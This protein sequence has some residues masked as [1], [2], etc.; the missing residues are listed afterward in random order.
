MVIALGGPDDPAPAEH[1]RS[2]DPAAVIPGLVNAHTHLEWSWVRG[3]MS[4]ARSMAAWASSLLSRGRTRPADIRAPVVAAIAE[5]R[6]Y[7]TTLVG[8]VTNTLETYGPLLDSELSARVFYELLGF[9]QHDPGPVLAAATAAI[10]RLTPVSWLRPSLVPHAPY[11]VSPEMLRAIG[12]AD[13]GVISIHLGESA[14]EIEFLRQGTGPWQELLQQLGAWD[15]SWTPPLA[16]PVEYIERLGLLS[17]RLLAVHCVQLTAAELER[18]AAAGSTIVTCPRSN[19]WTG[20][21][22]PDVGRFYASGVRLAVGTDSLGSV[23]DLNVFRELAL[24]RALAPEVPARRLLESATRIGAESLGFGADLGTIEPG[25]RAELIAVRVP[26]G[27]ED[28]E[29]YLVSGIRQSDIR[30]LDPD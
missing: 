30:W 29:E 20:A 26:R 1:T 21:G 9:T 13:D 8:E 15:A 22:L 17:D 3:Q 7:G 27:V 12:S 5:A 19:Q 4:A 24:M 28:V 6:A 2:V 18:L 23:E 14:E 25:K 16:G 11:S 10:E